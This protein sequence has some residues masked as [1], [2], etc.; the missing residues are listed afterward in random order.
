HR[1]IIL[2]NGLEKAA[3]LRFSRFFCSV[4]MRS[5]SL[6]GR[7]SLNLCKM[8]VPNGNIEA[9]QKQIVR[10]IAGINDEMY[11]SSIREALQAKHSKDGGNEIIVSDLESAGILQG[12][13]DV[14]AGNVYSTE[15]V[16]AAARAKLKR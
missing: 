13:R 14:E 15:E 11:L 9:L 8:K 2:S 10:L 3:G 12:I 16:Q 6:S 1:A 4:D 5:G 7:N